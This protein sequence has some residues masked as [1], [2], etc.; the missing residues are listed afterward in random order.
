MPR[1]KKLPKSSQRIPGQR[2][3]S[4]LMAPRGSKAMITL[5]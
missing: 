1:V 2:I 5:R 4:K 3:M